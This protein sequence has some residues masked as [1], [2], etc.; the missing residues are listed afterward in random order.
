MAACNRNISGI[1]IFISHLSSE[2]GILS[3]WIKGKKRN[4]SV[5][6]CITMCSQSHIRQSE[7]KFG[8]W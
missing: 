5:L 8:L 6:A 3:F 1:F 7:A 4:I 2:E